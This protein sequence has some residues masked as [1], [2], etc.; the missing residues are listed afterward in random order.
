FNGVETT[1]Q[2][3]LQPV[4]DFSEIAGKWAIESEHCCLGNNDMQ[5]NLIPVTPGDLVRGDV[6]GQNCD[7]SGAWQSWIVTTTDVTTGQSTVLNTAAAGGVPNEVNPGVLETYDVTSCDMLPAN[8]EITFD[9]VSVNPLQYYYAD[10]TS[11]GMV[12]AGFPTN[13]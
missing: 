4:L 6:S 2:D 1:L 8:G 3:I 12:P 13:C 10:F 9:D 7:G 11:G 5:S